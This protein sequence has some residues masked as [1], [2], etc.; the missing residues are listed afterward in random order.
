MN[1]M[2]TQPFDRIVFRK[3][4]SNIYKSHNVV[5]SPEVVDDILQTT[6]GHP[7]LSVWLLSKSVQQAFGMKILVLED[8]VRLKRWNFSFELHKTTNMTKLMNLAKNSKKQVGKFLHHLVTLYT[9]VCKEDREAS[10]LRAI[11]IAKLHV[12]PNVLTFTCPIIRDFLLQQLYPPSSSIEQVAIPSDPVPPFFMRSALL[13][14]ISF[15][16]APLVSYPEGLSQAAV[17]AEMFRILKS[18]FRNQ[19]VTIL[20][21]SRVLASSD[22]R[23][24]I[25]IKNSL[26]EFGVE[27]KTECDTSIF[28]REDHP[29]VREMV[30]LNFVRSKADSIVFPINVQT[31]GWE[32]YPNTSFS[33]IVV[34]VTSDKE[35]GFRLRYAVDGDR[36]WRELP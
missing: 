24:E 16:D 10:F 27:I 35:S 34:K 26:V 1:I 13:K 23:C 36:A 5:V 28:Q 31:A 21:E 33:L 4:A 12:Q 3:F 17:H 8:W 11:G 7:G 20:S 9:A 2:Q 15:I 14:A 32:R 18:M 25:W 19:S 29:S 6:C 22:M 30:L